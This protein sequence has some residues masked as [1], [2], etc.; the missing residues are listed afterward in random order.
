MTGKCNKCGGVIEVRNLQE[1]LV[2]ETTLASFVVCKECLISFTA[3]NENYENGKM[4]SVA[5]WM[6]S[7]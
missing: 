2:V 1:L 4:E 5:K 3:F 7:K 6:D